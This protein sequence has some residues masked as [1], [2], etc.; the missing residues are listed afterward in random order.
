MHGSGVRLSFTLAALLAKPSRYEAFIV[1]YKCT[2]GWALVFWYKS[3]QEAQKASKAS[4]VDSI[5]TVGL[6]L[7]LW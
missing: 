6:R 7:A 1:A 4:I 3:E 5:S 2:Y